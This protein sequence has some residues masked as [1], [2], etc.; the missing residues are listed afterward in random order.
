MNI[1]WHGVCI[2]LLLGVWD[3]KSILV[4]V[5]SYLSVLFATDLTRLWQWGFLPVVAITVQVVPIE[6][7]ILA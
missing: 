7:A 1:S 4:V 3:F 2:F 5:V 6:W